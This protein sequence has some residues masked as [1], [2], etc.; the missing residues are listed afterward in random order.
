L[1]ATRA[2][3]R[4]RNPGRRQG[5]PLFPIAIGTIVALG[6]LAII[7]TVSSNKDSNSSDETRPVTVEG[8]PLPRMP[9]DPANDP[10]IGM[11]AP[12]IAGESFAGDAVKI[13]DDGR[14]KVIAFVAHWC[15]HCRNEVPR[16]STYFK[17]T[18]M[19]AGVDFYF[20]STNADSNQANYPPSA[21]LKREGVSNIPTI[22][23]DAKKK[24]YATYGAGGFPYL[25]FVDK[26]NK[27]A[28]RTAGE[29]PEGSYDTYFNALASGA[30]PAP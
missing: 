17:D 2:R 20:V 14:A 7:L 28:L 24:A 26:G 6:V 5:L 15:P 4:K 18:G 8:T 16:L 12:T 1:S 27:V 13:T 21:W 10:A 11:T 30:P 9:Q 29:L 19:P 3:A 25:V 23:D 22:V